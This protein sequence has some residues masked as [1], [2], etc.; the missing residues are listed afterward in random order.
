MLK[1]VEEWAKDKSF[2]MALFVLQIVSN[3]KDIY[4]ALR[5][6]KDRRVFDIRT[7]AQCQNLLS[8]KRDLHLT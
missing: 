8:V 7:R 2:F 5:Y 1:D 4:E 3:S 6:I